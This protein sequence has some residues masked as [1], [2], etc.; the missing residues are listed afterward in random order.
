MRT[1]MD[2]IKEFFVVAAQMAVVLLVKAFAWLGYGRSPASKARTVPLGL[3]IEVP[4]I[5]M[6]ETL[7]GADLDNSAD[8]LEIME[9]ND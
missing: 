9:R 3:S 5:P 1:T 7:P 2:T 6:G 8:L 4:S